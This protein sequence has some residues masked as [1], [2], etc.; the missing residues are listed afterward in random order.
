MKQITRIGHFKSIFLLNYIFLSNTL[1]VDS[2]V[3]VVK[4]ETDMVRIFVKCLT[5]Q[6]P[7]NNL[8][9]PGSEGPGPYSMGPAYPSVRPPH[10]QTS[11]VTPAASSTLPSPQ[12]AQLQR[13][14]SQLMHQ[15]SH[16]INK[17][18]C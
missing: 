17:V 13:P 18:S 16:N 3:S 11:S 14:V 10:L 7:H 2:P 12:P 8:G 6:T 9:P 5:L 4:Q 15:V 1:C